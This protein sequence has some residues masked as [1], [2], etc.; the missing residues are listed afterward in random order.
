MTASFGRRLR[1]TS[2]PPL[3]DDDLLDEILLRLPPDPSSL[4]RASAVCTRWRRLV[5]DPGFVSRFLLRHRLRPPI[6]GCF[7]T[8]QRRATVSFVPTMEAPNRLPAERFSLQLGD[9]DRFSLLSCR[10]GLLLMFLPLWS[11]VLVWDPVAGDQ[12]RLDIPP[13][14][15]TKKEIGGAVLRAAGAV[16]HFQVV[17][18]GRDKQNILACVYSSEA[19]VWSKLISTPLPNPF[20]YE[21]MG[22]H[23]V[24][25]GDSLHWFINCGFHKILEF[26]LHRQILTVIPGP[27]DEFPV[28]ISQILVMRAEDGGLGVLFKSGCN[29]QLWKRKIDCDG[30]A[31]WVLG[32]TFD[33]DTLFSLNSEEIKYMVILGLAEYNST[34]FVRTVVGHFMV[35]LESLKFNKTFETNI[36]NFHQPFESVYTGET[37][38]GG[39]HNGAE[40]LHNT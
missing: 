1:P 17:L 9:R 28:G 39:G 2:A 7:I 14:F 8:D 25:V 33:L 12:H 36:W 6:L 38:I 10:H 4:P 5:S 24:L 16:R 32:R 22:V 3:D 35:Q 11:K 13:G 20:C 37:S 29:V 31:S 21:F 27:L 19:G 23:P 40:L 18:V 30:E 15:D 34:V 26:D